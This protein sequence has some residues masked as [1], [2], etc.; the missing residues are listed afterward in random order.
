MTNSISPIELKPDNAPLFDFQKDV[1]DFVTGVPANV[2]YR[3]IKAFH[4]LD[5]VAAVAR[6][7]RAILYMDAGLGKSRT[8]VEVAV[9]LFPDEP[10]LV[11]CSKKALNTWRREWMKW[12]TL[13]RSALQIVEGSPSQRRVQWANKEARIFVVTFQTGKNDYSRHILPRKFTNVIGDEVKLWRNRSA[14]NFV[15]WAP[16]LRKFKNVL[17]MDGTLASRGPQDL[18]TFLSIIEPRV[19]RSYWAF[20]GSFCETWDGPFGKEILGPKNTKQ[21]GLALSRHLI[22]ISDEDEEIQKQRPPLI[23]DVIPLDM[24]GEQERLYRQITDQMLLVTPEYDVVAAPSQLAVQVRQRQ[25]LICPKILSP[26]YGYGSAIEHAMMELEDDPHQVFFTPYAKALPFISDAIVAA[27]FKAPFIL[28]GGTSS[29]QVRFVEEEFAKDRSK[30]RSVICT[31]GFAESFELPSAKQCRHIGFEWSQLMNIQ[32]EKRLM[33]MITPHPVNSW[34]YVYENTV[35]DLMRE[36]LNKKQTN[37]NITFQ[38][39]I[40]YLKQRK[41]L[42]LQEAEMKKTMGDPKIPS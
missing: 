37:V 42:A 1:V 23:R 38:D 19:Y 8:A 15:F 5:I 25:L 30:E 4:G 35:D 10:I 18:W 32:A 6:K 2:H 9:R 34:Y 28:K 26:S 13:G 14:K 3:T 39:Y 40:S 11:L 7:G 16:I 12:T 27:G 33:R 24:T 29:D 36:V 20:V 21:L 22:R 41:L 31:T 17:L